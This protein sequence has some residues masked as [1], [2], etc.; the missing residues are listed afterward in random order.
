M[1]SFRW[2]CSLVFGDLPAQ[3]AFPVLQP[4]EDLLIIT[5]TQSTPVQET[6]CL[7]AAAKAELSY[8]GIN[9]LLNVVLQVR[10]WGEKKDK[11][12]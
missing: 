1:G 5:T 9:P 7:A 4:P 2:Q 3:F 12:S 6:G 8:L 11:R 10:L